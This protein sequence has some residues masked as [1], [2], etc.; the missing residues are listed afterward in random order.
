MKNGPSPEW[1]QRRLRAIGLRPINALVDITN[2]ITYDRGRPLHVFDAA[3]VKGDLIVRRARAG[4]T[5]V[6]LDGKTYT[7]DPEICVIADDARR[8]VDR[9]HHGRRGVRLRPKHD[10]R[11]DRIGA[12]GAA[13]RRRRPAASSASTPTPAT[14]SSAASIPAF[15]L[16]GLELATRMVIDLCGGTP[17]EI[18]VAGE[19][20]DPRTVIDFPVAE[21]KRLAGIDPSVSDVTAILERARLRLQAAPRDRH[22][23][24]GG[25][26]LAAGRDR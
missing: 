2:F 14:A 12:V 6:A 11:A 18:V 23:H 8:R 13:Q 25:A 26:D 3:K 19:V 7:L 22:D 16:P 5:V 10:R 17:S 9:R 1:L 20:P 4:E 24:R 21:I 15:M